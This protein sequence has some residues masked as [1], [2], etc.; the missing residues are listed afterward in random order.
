MIITN[1]AK[2]ILYWYDPPGVLSQEMD[3]DQ[4]NLLSSTQNYSS[5]IAARQGSDLTENI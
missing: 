2:L 5:Y 1:V 4:G 3:P